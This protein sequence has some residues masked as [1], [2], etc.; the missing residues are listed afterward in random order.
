MSEPKQSDN[1][2]EPLSI[3]KHDR[4]GDKHSPMASQRI[5]IT[6]LI[7]LIVII[8]GFSFEAYLHQHLLFSWMES[9]YYR[10]EAAI[11]VSIS[12]GMLLAG[13]LL[14]QLSHI[15][16]RHNN[17]IW[18][19]ITLVLFIFGSVVTATA[20]SIVLTNYRWDYSYWRGIA[21]ALLLISVPLQKVVEIAAETNILTAYKFNR[22]VIYNIFTILYMFG[23]VVL[24]LYEIPY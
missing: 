6:V 17:F 7:C 10:S 23:I 24:L 22:K 20:E 16:L 3:S 13:F 12:T 5:L 18:Q 8:T 14:L 2:F 4:L 19:G 11:A 21:F 15:L 9:D 1:K